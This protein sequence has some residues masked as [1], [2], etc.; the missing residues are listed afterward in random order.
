MR[1]RDK[2]ACGSALVLLLCLIGWYAYT[3]TTAPGLYSTHTRDDLRRNTIAAID[4]AEESVH[5]ATYHL[6]EESVIAALNRAAERGREVVV[7]F[8]GKRKHKKLSKLV[9]QLP[10]KPSG[11]MHRK[12][13]SVDGHAAHLGSANMTWD[14]LRNH[15]NCILQIEDEEF[16]RHLAKSIEGERG[17][18]EGGKLRYWD[19]PSKEALTDLIGLLDGAQRS[20][21]VAMFTFT[22]PDLCDALIRAHERGV[23]VRVAIDKSTARGASRKVSKALRDAKIELYHSRGPELLHHKMCWIDQKIFVIGSANWTKAAFTRNEDDLLILKMEGPKLR[24][25]LRAI[26]WEG[27]RISALLAPCQQVDPTRWPQD[28]ESR[29]DSRVQCSERPN[30]MDRLSR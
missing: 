6:Y 1:R 18:F 10:T 25:I 14:S 23:R 28:R 8:H 22:H 20:I 4:R 17:F 16:A 26:F 15:A 19:L 30:T 12:L 3:P 27:R 7:R 5:L 9:D 13:L 24:K 2:A 29:R 11:L 21:D